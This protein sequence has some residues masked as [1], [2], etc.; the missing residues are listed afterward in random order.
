M[1]GSGCLLRGSPIHMATPATPL[2]VYNRDARSW[3]DCLSMLLGEGRFRKGVATRTRRQAKRINA[4]L[5]KNGT[6]ARIQ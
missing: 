5:L 3:L 2:A 6:E 4:T 1:L